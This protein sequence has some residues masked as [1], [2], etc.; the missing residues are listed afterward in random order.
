MGLSTRSAIQRDRVDDF[1][2]PAAIPQQFQLKFLGR[3]PIAKETD[4]PYKEEKL[5]Y[6]RCRKIAASLL[7]LGFAVSCSSY[8]R[9]PIASFS[10]RLQDGD[11][12]L[13]WSLNYFNSWR[14]ERQPQ[15]LLLAEDHTVNAI[16]AFSQLESDTSPRI[17]EYYVARER[18][19]R[20]CRLLAEL[21][22]EA[23]NH[24]QALRGM[25]PSGC[26]Y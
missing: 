10:T 7:L 11:R 12:H 23:I 21:Q 20:G 1:Q 3:L 26:T 5:M 6:R 22:F 13:G 2:Q 4:H 19:T 17:N 18:R 8:D 9:F 24:G 25:T 15:Y 14:R 16:D